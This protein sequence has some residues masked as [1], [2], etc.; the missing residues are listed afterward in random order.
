MLFS[1]LFIYISSIWGCSGPMKVFE[2]NFF[3]Q[4]IVQTKNK[5]SVGFNVIQMKFYKYFSSTKF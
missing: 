5:E 3:I 1:T 2:T 4:T